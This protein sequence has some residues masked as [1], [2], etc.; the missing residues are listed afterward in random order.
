MMQL[1]LMPQSQEDSEDFVFQQDET[2]SNIHFDVR[3][4]LNANFP[5]V[6]LGA[7]LTMTLPFFPGLHDHLT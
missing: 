3:V 2:P 1:R 6:G 5:V 4:H 7:L